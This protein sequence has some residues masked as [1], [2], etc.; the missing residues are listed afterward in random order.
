M[1]WPSLTTSPPGPFCEALFSGLAC[2]EAKE[3]PSARG[4]GFQAQ[5][6]AGAPWAPGGVERAVPGEAPCA[7]GPIRSFIH[8][9]AFGCFVRSVGCIRLVLCFLGN[10]EVNS[11]SVSRIAL[12]SL[13]DFVCSAFASTRRCS[14]PFTPHPPPH[15]RLHPFSFRASDSQ[16]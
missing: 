16:T 15:P 3:A 8:E 14:G 2:Q 10:F 5:E 9:A 13:S 12:T 4:P 1:F 7:C 6:A 11:Y